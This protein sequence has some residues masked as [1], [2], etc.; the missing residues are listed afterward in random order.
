M[1]EGGLEGEAGDAEEGDAIEGLEVEAAEEDLEGAGEDLVV[2][3]F[4]FAEVGEG[5]EFIAADAEVGD[6]GDVDLF[7]DEDGAGIGVGA[8]A[9]DGRMRLDGEAAGWGDDADDLEGMAVAG[10]EDVVDFF[11]FLGPADEE[12]ALAEVSGHGFAAEQAAEKEPPG[13]EADHAFEACEQAVE[14]ADGGIEPQ[15]EAEGHEGEE[16]GE[17]GLGDAVG[18]VGEGA[19]AV[20][21]VELK[22]HQQG[23]EQEGAEGELSAVG[24]EIDA[25]IQEA[26]EFQFGMKA[27]CIGEEEHE[28]DHEEVHGEG[29]DDEALREVAAVGA[30][31]VTLCFRGGCR[32]LGWWE[33]GVHSNGISVSSVGAGGQG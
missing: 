19:E 4:A 31:V 32:V 13:E 15:Y 20:R 12:E 9:G 6:E 14:P 18:G 23:H 2:D 5:G 27:Q 10:A 16:P 28:H 21:A 1:V 26:D 17:A 7:A 22:F 30:V 3:E 11:A 29:G 8:E 33:R 25:V 24:D